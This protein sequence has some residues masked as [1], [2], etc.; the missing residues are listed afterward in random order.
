MSFSFASP[1]LP[2]ARCWAQRQ[3]AWL[4]R[5][6]ITP[7]PGP[8][9][10]VFVSPSGSAIPP[11]FPHNQSSTQPPGG[12]LLKHRLNP[13]MAFLKNFPWLP[14]P[15]R[16]RVKFLIAAFKAFSFIHFFIRSLIHIT[17]RFLRI[18]YVPGRLPGI[19]TVSKTS[20]MPAILKLPI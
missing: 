6:G 18:Y 4:G 17:N 1:A 14:I 8:R 20:N 11:A 2:A 9:C 3:Q 13:D 5:G 15:S 16:P 10:S 19:H 7:K 12:S